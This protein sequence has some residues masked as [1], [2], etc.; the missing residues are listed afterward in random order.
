[1]SEDS[2]CI[3]AMDYS[4]SI[5]SGKDVR[6]PEPEEVAFTI[7]PSTGRLNQ[8]RRHVRRRRGHR[9]DPVQTLRRHHLYTASQLVVDMRA[10]FPHPR[11][12][13]GCQKSVLGC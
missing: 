2:K 3:H 6:Q 5:C 9:N 4:Y 1:M 11:L 8:A 7:P 12:A 13:V 10:R